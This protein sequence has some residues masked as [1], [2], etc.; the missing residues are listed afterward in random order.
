[1]TSLVLELQNLA[2]S[3]SSTLPELL[4]KAK[5][6]AFKLGLDDF[7]RW[8]DCELEGYK[9]HKDVPDY[10]VVICEL[11]A[12]HPFHGLQQ[13]DFNNSE[14]ANMFRKIRIQ[15]GVGNLVGVMAAS[16]DG[17]AQIPLVEAEKQW[18]ANHLR[19]PTRMSIIRQYGINQI[20]GILDVVQT[21]LLN[22]SLEL[23]K[24]G[25]LGE[26]MTFSKEEKERAHTNIHIQTVQ[27]IVGDVT[28]SRVTQNLE[29]HVKAGDFNSLAA[30]L[31]KEGVRPKEIDELKIAIEGDGKTA[32][33]GKFGANVKEWLERV[34][35][36]IGT[37]AAGGTIARAIGAYFG[38]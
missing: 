14:Y 32:T 6:V 35:T 21:K 38:F 25:I 26:G 15:Q 12:V 28:N 9:D 20:A 1:M 4:R 37:S 7:Q 16:D 22:W 27:G 29:L 30:H 33:K 23:E 36:S 34:T 17:I 24:Q 11:R 2:S 31:S 8:I 5:L 18:I 19:S 13:I 10:R 3:S